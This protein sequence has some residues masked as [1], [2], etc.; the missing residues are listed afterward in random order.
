MLQFR[1][2]GELSLLARLASGL[3]A[4]FCVS[5]LPP[6]CAELDQK[7]LEVVASHCISVKSFSQNDS[8]YARPYL[9]INK[10][11][12]NNNNRISLG[13]DP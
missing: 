4:M 13:I 12:N 11:I 8:I 6:A 7:S 2:K 10:Y 1:D 3:T 9:R 5:S